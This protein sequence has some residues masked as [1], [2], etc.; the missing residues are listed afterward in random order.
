VETKQKEIQGGGGNSGGGGSGGGSNHVQGRVPDEN[1]P[2]TGH[3][4]HRGMLGHVCGGISRPVGYCAGRLYRTVTFMVHISLVFFI[5]CK[6]AEP[7]KELFKPAPWLAYYDRFFFVNAQVRVRMG[8]G[9]RGGGLVVGGRWSVVGGRQGCR[10]APW[11][12]G[13]VQY[14]TGVGYRAAGWVNKQYEC[15]DICTHSRVLVYV[16][17]THHHTLLSFSFSFP[18]F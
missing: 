1:P 13:R 15:M 14:M 9:G 4:G 17:L 6:S 18:F 8:G 5:L 2:S 16:S 12:Y 3:K 7:M 11:L 10:D